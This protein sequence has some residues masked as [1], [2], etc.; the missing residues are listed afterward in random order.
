MTRGHDGVTDGQRSCKIPQ[1]NPAAGAKDDSTWGIGSCK[2]GP[3]SIVSPWRPWL[4]F[5]IA[6]REETVV[7]QIFQSVYVCFKMVITSYS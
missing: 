6:N 3:G 4:T 1:D 7:E 5:W 2:G